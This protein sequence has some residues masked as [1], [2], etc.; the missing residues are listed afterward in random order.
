MLATR[1]PFLGSSQDK[2]KVSLFLQS[3]VPLVVLIVAAFNVDISNTEIETILLTIASIAN[4]CVTLYAFVR[5]F[6]K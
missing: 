2:T 4:G 3:L 6:L 1:Y 5:K